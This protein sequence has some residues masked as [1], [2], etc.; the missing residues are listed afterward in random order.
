MKHDCAL[1]LL[2]AASSQYYLGA[3]C[4]TIF[5]IFMY[6]NQRIYSWRLQYVWFTVFP[7]ICQTDFS[8]L[9]SVLKI[10]LGLRHI[11]HSALKYLK[12]GSRLAVWQLLCAVWDAEGL[13]RCM[14]SKERTVPMNGSVT[15]RLLLLSLIYWFQKV[16][17]GWP[18]YNKL[19]SYN[20][21]VFLYIHQKCHLLRRIAS[22]SNE[23][24][25]LDLLLYFNIFFF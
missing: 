25:S 10:I 12:S 24:I 15:E 11:W 1:F 21:C 5:S 7:Y 2:C 18:Y 4:S 22:F 14:L 19:L 9:G 3:Q 6:K 17:K 13:S 8:L 16:P 20:A 23:F